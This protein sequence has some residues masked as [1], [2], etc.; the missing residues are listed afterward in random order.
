MHTHAHSIRKLLLPPAER[1]C[2][3]SVRRCQL[4]SAQLPIRQQRALIARPRHRRRAAAGST[5][6]SLEAMC[7]R[8]HWCTRSTWKTIPYVTALQS[9][10]SLN[11]LRQL[12]ASQTHR[13]RVMF[14]ADVYI[15]ANAGRSR[16]RQQ[17]SRRRIDRGF[18][19][20]VVDRVR[21]CEARHWRE[22]LLIR[23]RDRGLHEVMGNLSCVSCRIREE[24]QVS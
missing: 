23:S 16:S 9:R 1:F 11:L 10:N 17:V 12:P 4:I 2:R 19:W 21:A 8:C 5:L 15:W 13:A 20:Q 3:C 18:Y 22:H 14:C 24:K 6:C 7:T